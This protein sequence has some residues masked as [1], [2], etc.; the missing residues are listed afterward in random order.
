MSGHTPRNVRERIASLLWRAIPSTSDEDAKAQAQQLLDDYR[1]E[2]IQKAIGRL[3]SIPIQ[4]TALTGPAW[5][6]TGWND[7]IT[8]LEE[9]ADYQTP[10]D[11]AYTG[12]LELL[13]AL[14]LN[15]RAAA[16]KGDLNF[17]RHLS[18]QH[19][20]ADKTAREQKQETSR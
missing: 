3:R 8:Q 20:Q 4:C 18:D 6:G 11:E 15:M 7:A 14:T 16:R 10:D 19:H 5:Y 2:A 17:V 1:R 9:I 12:E 13:R